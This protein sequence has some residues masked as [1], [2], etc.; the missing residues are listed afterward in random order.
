MEKLMQKI[1]A[2][3][4]RVIK[5][6]E[7]KAGNVAYWMSR[8]QRVDYNYALLYAQ[9][10]AYE[11][12][13]KLFVVFNLVPSFL[14]ATIRQY[15][16]MLKGIKEVEETLKELNIPFILVIGDSAENIPRFV[17]EYK[18][19]LLITDFNPL[20]IKQNWNKK[21]SKEISI[22]FFEV[23]TH[24]IVPAFYVSNKK[25]FG[26]NTF[27]AKIK[28][29]LEEFLKEPPRITFHIFND[30]NLKFRSFDVLEA[31]KELKVDR[32]VGP[33]SK[34]TPG[35]K[36]GRKVL[37]VF[38]REKLKKYHLL[39][40]DPNSDVQSNLSP[41]LHFGQLSSLEVAL[42]VLEADAP[43]KAKEV[44]LDELI[45]RKELADNFCLYEEN[46]DNI[47]GIPSWARETL[48]KHKKDK[49]K[50]IYSLDE[51]ENAKT[52]DMLWNSAQIQMVEEGKM[53]GYLRMYWAKKILEWTESPEEAIKIAIYLNDKYELDGR[54]PNGYA[55]ILW[56]IGGLHDKP[57]K[58]RPI[59]GKI[60]YMSFEGCRRKFD[61]EKFISRYF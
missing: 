44:F 28:R 59:F 21:V 42:K 9:K 10:I 51:L 58:E 39:K 17:K 57:F 15:D 6:G 32:K 11:F 18:I 14:D 30:K 47:D 56:S 16:F 50:Y 38:I 5:E 49:R 46:Y 20:R 22:P 19:S 53:H 37:S 24:N 13:S 54:D 29:V 4:V 55:G 35:T 45:V 41:Y 40:N 43:K 2:R 25:E 7:I 60:R 31:Q 1:D 48:E 3:R 52:H 27:R 8:D 33:V 36:E 23:D 34:F 26:A 61:V 12:K